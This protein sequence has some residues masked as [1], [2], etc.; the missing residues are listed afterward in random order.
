MAFAPG[1][2]ETVR[3]VLGAA[4]DADAPLLS[5]ASDVWRDLSFGAIRWQPPYAA[6]GFLLIPLFIAGLFGAF[7][8]RPAHRAS[9]DSV[10]D[11][12]PWLFALIVFVPLAVSALMFRTLA[13]R[14]IL[15]VVPFVLAFVAYGV[16]T[17]WP[18]NRVLGIAL[19]IM[20]LSVA[21]A[22]AFHYFGPYTKSEY[23]EMARYLQSR[24][25]ATEDTVLIEA[26]RQHLLTKYYLGQAFPLQPVPDISLPEY[27]PLTAPRI[28]PEDVDDVVQAALNQ[29]TGIWLILSAEAEVDP[30]EF[31]AKYMS[32]VAFR[33]DCRQWLDV[34]LCRFVDPE[35]VDIQLTTATDA[36]YAGGLV[37]EKAGLGIAVDQATEFETPLMVKLDWWA[38]EQP[39]A[40]RM[41]SLKLVSDSGEVV[42]QAD[43]LPIG[44]L[45]PPTTWT[46]GDRKPGYMVIPLPADLSS[47][48]YSIQA[49]VYDPETLLPVPATTTSGETGITVLELGL[50]EI[51]DTIRLLPPDLEPGG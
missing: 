5:F 6:I 22:G 27:W 15:Y 31:L 24:Y 18:V 32:A 30:G 3:V 43:K 42:G 12:W 41:V 36:H 25:S 13:T 7:H 17:L 33:Q 14:Y 48:V 45:L 38:K 50:L 1:F 2:Q 19:G 10:Y 29:S 26:P 4:K 46:E 23:R 34:R 47:G 40:D 51:D 8:D 9:G 28:V 49:E 16:T 44:P 11:R 35:S 20:A 37:L 21:A 39:S